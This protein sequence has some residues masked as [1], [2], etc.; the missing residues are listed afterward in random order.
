METATVVSVSN[1]DIN[2]DAVIRAAREAGSSSV[3]F[4]TTTTTTTAEVS[5]PGPPSAPA[6][7]VGNRVGGKRTV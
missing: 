6:V 3:R 5:L 1:S 4:T 2:P 7:V